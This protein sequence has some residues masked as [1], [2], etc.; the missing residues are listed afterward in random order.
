MLTSSSCRNTRT[1]G[2]NLYLKEDKTSLDNCNIYNSNDT[3]V[4]F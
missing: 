2:Q 4:H 1:M 3:N